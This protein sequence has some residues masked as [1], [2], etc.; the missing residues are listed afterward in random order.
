MTS[1][2]GTMTRVHRLTQRGRFVDHRQTRLPEQLLGILILR[3]QPGNEVAIAAIFASHLARGVVLQDL[4]KQPRTAPAIHQNVMAGPD[5]LVLLGAQ[6]QQGHP[7]QSRFGQVEAQRA[8]SAGELGN[9]RLAAILP[10]PIEHLHLQRRLAMDDLQRLGQAVLP[11]ETGAQDRLTH[12]DELPGP[13]ETLHV[14]ALDRQADLLHVEAAAVIRQR[15]EQHAFLHRRQRIDVFDQF[16]RHRQGI[17]L[18][19]IQLRQRVVGGAGGLRVCQRNHCGQF[20]HRLLLEQVFGREA[21]ALLPRAADQLNRDDRITAEGEEIVGHADLLDL[22]NVLPDLGQLLLQRRRRR[23][24]IALCLAGIRCRQSLAIKFAVGCQ[25]QLFEEQPLRRHHVVRQMR[26]ERGLQLSTQ[27]VQLRG[28]L[29]G[30]GR[31]HISHQLLAANAVDRQHHA[32]A[33]AGLGQQTRFDF[34][35]FNT[36]AAHLDLMVDAADVFDTAVV[37]ETRQVA[38]AVHALAVARQRVGHETFGGQARAQQ[39]ATGDAFTGQIQLRC[40]ADRRLLQLLVEQV[41]SGIAQRPADIGLATEFATGPGRIRGVFGRPVQV[42][43]VGDRSFAVQGVDQRLLERLAGQIDDAHARRDLADALQRGNRRRH[44]VDQA[45]LI[46]LGQVRQLQGIARHDHGPAARQG[47]ENLPHRQVEA[48]RRRGQ[49]ALQIVLAVDLGG[50]VNQRLYVAMGDGHAFRFAGGTGG[51]DHVGQI[52]RVGARRQVVRCLRGERFATGLDQHHVCFAGRQ[53]R[54]QRMLGQQDFRLAVIEHVGHAVG[55]VVRVQRHVGAAGLEHRHQGDHQFRR[56]RQRHADAHFCG[57]TQRHQM[58][59]QLV[60]AAVQ[61][62]V[63]QGHAGMTQRQCLRMCCD[64]RFKA[65]RNQP[66]GRISRVIVVPLRQRLTLGQRQQTDLAECPLRRCDK[67]LEHF[68]QMRGQ[69]EHAALGEVFGEV[70]E[71]EVEHFAGAGNQGQTVVGLLAMLQTGKTQPAR[72]GLQRF[73]HRVVLEHQQSV[74]QRFATQCGQTLNVLQRRLFV[75]AQQQVLVLHAA[76]P[77]ADAEAGLRAGDHRQGVDEQP[78]LLLDARQIHR[79]PGYRG[80]K[81]NGGLAGVALQHQQPRG[82]HQTV[83]GHLLLTGEAVQALG[84]RFIEMQTMHLFA[85]PRHGASVAGR[86]Q[87]GRLVEFG[88]LPAPEFLRG[89]LVLALQ[90]DQKIAI[91]TLRARHRLAG[92]I[93]QHLAEHPRVAPAIH[94]DVV[95]GKNQSMA[96]VGSAQQA[97]AQQRRILQIEPAFTVGLRP[98]FKQRRQIGGIAHI[99]FRHFQGQLAV[100]H[101]QRCI[102]AIAAPDETGAQ[103]FMAINHP[104]PGLLEPRNVEAVDVQ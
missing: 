101:L 93:L 65:L 16:R 21:N 30:L 55:R 5:H 73:G 34:T 84:Q 32:F 91:A 51:V 42:V 37:H 71:I 100:D 2:V 69:S 102:E 44:S 19:L 13:A 54:Q 78:Q 99:D 56:T 88:Q 59:G 97:Q 96:V 38:G 80:A 29:I 74:E 57:D 47:D 31:Y 15:M 26:L 61:F 46:T 35:Q 87:S 95:A 7:L 86:G 18:R 104:L 17:E 41:R 58:P 89:C 90:P 70:V 6:L 8:I 22:Q 68:T 4:T 23:D 3:L 98:R 14:E 33:H 10:T 43:N 48:H 27:R 92:V 12:N 77:I 20:L 45:H 85:R 67:L 64:P 1:N 82:L 49:H 40:D 103:H 81:R 63:T 36:E 39:I 76:H 94:E 79:T 11:M 75:V 60:C 83:E 24:V 66:L 52:G 53:L 50:P 25:R 28:A 9:R 72:I 62:A